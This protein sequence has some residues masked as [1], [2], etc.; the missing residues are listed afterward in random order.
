MF[1]SSGTTRAKSPYQPKLLQAL[2][3]S[4]DEENLSMSSEE[5]V[6]DDFDQQKHS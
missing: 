1:K 6:D 5:H 4:S 3:D 2:I